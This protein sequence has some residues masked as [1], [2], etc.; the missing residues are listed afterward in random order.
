MPQTVTVQLHPGSAMDRTV[1]AP[2]QSIVSS[3]EWIGFCDQIDGLVQPA[4]KRM[5]LY[6]GGMFCG[7]VLGAIILVTSFIAMGN[8]SLDCLSCSGFQINAGVIIGPIVI[9]GSMFGGMCLLMTG[10]SRI[11][12]KI[13]GACE[14]FS[15]HY[16]LMSVHYKTYTTTSREHRFGETRRRHHTD[17]FL[18]IL[19]ADNEPPARE[20]FPCNEMEV[21]MANAVAISVE[22]PSGSAESKGAPSATATVLVLAP[23]ERMEQL[24][25]MRGMLTKEEYHAK[26][27]EILDSV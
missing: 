11:E 16:P 27:T 13:K 3:G 5:S 10:G 24:E 6:G 26:R 4:Q 8:A 7:F 12:S 20:I 14:D 18:E 22:V 1:P 9:L 19:V 15:K 23:A 2:I 17:Y 21:E 25:Q